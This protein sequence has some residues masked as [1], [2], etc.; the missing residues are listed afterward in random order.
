MIGVL[1]Q[2]AGADSVER[3][4]PG[5]RRGRALAEG[6]RRDALR[7]A[8]H[9]VGRAAREGQQQDAERIGAGFDQPHDAVRQGR[10]L[11]GAGAGN[12]Q[13]RPRGGIADAEL[14]CRPLLGIERVQV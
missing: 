12:D 10:G 5:E 14:D 2:Q 1:P 7:P 13:E 3:P 4:R 11:A 9:L 8:H 6:P